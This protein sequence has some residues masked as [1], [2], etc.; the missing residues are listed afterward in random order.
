MNQKF[1]AAELRSRISAELRVAFPDQINFDRATAAKI[2]GVSR[3]HLSNCELA[4]KPLLPIVRI[5]RKPL[6]QFP[7]MVDFLVAQRLKTQTRCGPR[8]KAERLADHQTETGGA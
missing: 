2:V 1:S 5:G 7:D 6:V 8:T 4:G 3:G